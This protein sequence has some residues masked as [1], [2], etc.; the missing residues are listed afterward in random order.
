LFGLAYWY[1][2]YPIHGFMFS[3]LI[4]ALADDAAASR[5]DG[6]V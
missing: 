2:L 3:R 1:L 4:R 6:A 5:T